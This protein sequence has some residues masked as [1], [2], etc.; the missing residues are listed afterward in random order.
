MKIVWTDGGARLDP[1][2]GH[3]Y[4]AKV[5]MRKTK[6]NNVQEYQD[7]ALLIAAAPETAAERDRLRAINAELLAALIKWSEIFDAYSGPC[8]RTDGA[9]CS[10]IPVIPCRAC[11]S[12]ANAAEARAAIAKA[13]GGE[14]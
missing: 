9:H 14:P 10:M 5:R 4:I 8:E 13:T 1:E 12:R 2:D 6:T 3:G 11:A 7:Y